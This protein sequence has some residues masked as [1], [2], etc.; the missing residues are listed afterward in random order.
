MVVRRRKTS[1][2]V[3]SQVHRLNF[4]RCIKNVGW[5]KPMTENDCNRMPKHC[6][7]NLHDLQYRRFSQALTKVGLALFAGQPTLKKV[8]LRKSTGPEAVVL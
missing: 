2:P 1:G 7:F 4:F 6:H 8:S 3:I 5:M